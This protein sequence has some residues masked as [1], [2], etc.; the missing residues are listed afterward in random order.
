MPAELNMLDRDTALFYRMWHTAF[1]NNADRTVTIRSWLS[2]LRGP[3]RAPC[4]THMNAAF[5]YSQVYNL[6]ALANAVQNT[7]GPRFHEK[8]IIESLLGV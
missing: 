1:M 3:K 5:N 7:G 6:D 4:A 8:S 2:R